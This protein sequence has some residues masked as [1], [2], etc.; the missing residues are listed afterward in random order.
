[1]GNV[2]LRALHSMAVVEQSLELMWYMKRTDVLAVTRSRT[3]EERARRHIHG[4]TGA[5]FSKG[6]YMTLR[7][8]YIGTVTTFT[9]KDC[10]VAEFYET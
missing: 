9:T 3:A 6:K 1:M 5:T 4:E 8:G 2:R 7:R 10:L